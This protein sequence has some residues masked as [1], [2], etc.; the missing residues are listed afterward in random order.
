MKTRFL[1]HAL[2]LL[3]LLP[4]PSLA[5]EPTV[6]V[7][8]SGRA[9]TGLRVLSLEVA[10]FRDETV[11]YGL[12]ER[13]IEQIYRKRLSRAGF[14]LV[15]RARTKDLSRAARLQLRLYSN[16]TDYGYYSY[17]L[18]LRLRQKVRLGEDGVLYAITWEKY[19]QGIA[20][21]VE[22][23]KIGRQ[24]QELLEEFL[25]AHRRENGGTP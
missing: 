13:E 9:L 2:L 22:L 11:R 17:L 24:A 15:E 21:D 14:E 6:E 23:P 19:R 7:E 10:G 1:P 12:D 8:L 3:L 20:R 18:A 25:E 16:R 5:T 4:F